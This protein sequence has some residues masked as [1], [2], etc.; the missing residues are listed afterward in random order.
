MRLLVS[1]LEFRFVT[2]FVAAFVTLFLLP[3]FYRHILQRTGA[4]RGPRR[5]CSA[6]CRPRRTRPWIRPLGT[7]KNSATTCSATV[8][9]RDHIFQITLPSGD[10]AGFSGVV[11]KPF[12]Q[13][14]RTTQEI[15][16]DLTQKAAKVPGIGA[17]IATPQPL[18]GGS[19]FD[20]EFVIASTGDPRTLLGYAKKIQA[21]ADGERRQ[22]VLAAGSEVRSTAIPDRLRSGQGGGAWA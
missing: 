12:S 10:S 20:I 22:P 16:A 11:T 21:E 3:I 17:I 1:T 15:L 2:L 9:E 7:R 13:R 5:W 8:P 14:K 18:P 6:S 4:E 19:N